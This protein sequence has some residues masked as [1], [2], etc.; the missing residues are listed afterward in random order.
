MCKESVGGAGVLYAYNII[1]HRSPPAK[2]GDG[3]ILDVP[4][5][6]IL[7]DERDRSKLCIIKAFWIDNPYKRAPKHLWGAGG[8]G[9]GKIT[10]NRPKSMGSRSTIVLVVVSPRKDGR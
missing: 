4:L 1:A 7:N 9:E 8:V 2:E 5:H 6:E 10:T 3:V